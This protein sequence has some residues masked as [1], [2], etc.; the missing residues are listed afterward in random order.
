MGH[1]AGQPADRLHLLS[2]MGLV[3]QASPDSLG[4]L[5]LGHVLADID[6]TDDLAA[7]VQQG[8]GGIQDRPLLTLGRLDHHLFVGGKLAPDRPQDSP[9]VGA[10]RF[11]GVRPPAPMPGHLRGPRLSWPSP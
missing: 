9:L 4:G 6:R 8:C 1:A 10:H 2:L 3:L 5:G 11:A 7:F